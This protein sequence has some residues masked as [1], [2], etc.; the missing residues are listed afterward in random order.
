MAPG[1]RAAWL[2]PLLVLDDDSRARYLALEEEEQVL[3]GAHFWILADPL[4]TRDGNEVFSE[5]LARW[6]ETDLQIGSEPTDGSPWREDLIEVMIRFGT[7]PQWIRGMGAFGMEHEFQTGISIADRWS[8]LNSEFEPIGSVFTDREGMIPQEALDVSNQS[9]SDSGMPLVGFGYIFAPPRGIR[10]LTVRYTPPRQSLLPP[11]EVL[12]AGTMTEG[13]WG[14]EEDFPLS[15]YDLPMGGAAARWFSPLA[16]QLAV[17]PRGDSVVVVAAYDLPAHGV[18]PSVR[19]DAGFALLPADDGLGEMR[20]FRADGSAGTGVFAMTAEAVPSF[21]SLEL[22]IP[23]EGALARARYGVD[24]SPRPMGIPLLSDLLLITEGAL[25]ESLPGAVATARP[26][27]R[28]LP[29]EELGIYWE[30]H[31]LDLLDLAEVPLSL[32]LHPPPSGRLVGA[33]QWLG[34]RIG[35]LEDIMP[36]RTSWVEEVGEGSFMGRSIGFRFP[37]EREGRYLI[38]LRVELPGREPLIALQEVE[39]TRSVLPT[40]QTAI[41]VRRPLLTRIVAN[42]GPGYPRLR[43]FIPNGNGVGPDDPS[44]YGHYGGVRHLSEFGYDGW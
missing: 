23:E 24:L 19:V 40:S 11:G 6:I 27:T 29:G 39:V 12:F 25:P 8:Y 38:E 22:V 9:I 20:T 28:A 13:S 5:H 37:E 44:I 14:V 4:W 34:E 1:E 17:F 36:I 31:G 41:L 43:C 3:A 33:L 42:C 26:S 30:L 21:L 15:G 18:S 7:S 10:D 16:H 35:L 2:S 32:A